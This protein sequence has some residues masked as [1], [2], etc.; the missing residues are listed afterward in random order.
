MSATRLVAIGAFLTVGLVFAAMELLARREGAKLPTLGDLCGYVM[1]YRAG[2]LPV[3]RI[4]AYGFWW[5][6]GWHLFAR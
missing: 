1:R 3:G 4:A 6:L 2:G 5:W